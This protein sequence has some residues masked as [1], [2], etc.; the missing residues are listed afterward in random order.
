[1]ISQTQSHGLHTEMILDL[2]QGFLFMAAAAARPTSVGPA[3]SW[4]QARL[5]RKSTL[6]HSLQI[7]IIK[8]NCWILGLTKY[9]HVLFVCLFARIMLL[10]FGCIE[11]DSREHSF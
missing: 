9:L 7:T 6:F 10:I 5:N 2:W 1:M 4:C 11:F 8:G 3:N